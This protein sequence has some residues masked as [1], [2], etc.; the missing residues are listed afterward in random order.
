MA[1]TTFGTDGSKSS[2]IA[3]CG[4]YCE[5][6]GKYTK[7]KCPGCEKNEKASWCAIRKC[8]MDNSYRS[9]AECA[10]F[11]NPMDCKKYNNPIAKVIGFLFNSDR[12]KGIEY[13]RKNGYGAFSKQMDELG[14]MSM[15]RK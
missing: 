6:C 9:C 15:K 2:N 3:F 4:L 1:K 7:G 13:I 5:A 10:T 14:R 11:S 8:C 12:S